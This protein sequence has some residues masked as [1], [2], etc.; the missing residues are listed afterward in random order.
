MPLERIF[1][2][3]KRRFIGLDPETKRLA[4]LEGEQATPKTAPPPPKAIKALSGSGL[5]PLVSGSSGIQVAAPV[6]IP[7]HQENDLRAYGTQLRDTLLGGELVQQSVNVEA[8]GSMTISKTYAVPGLELRPGIAN[9]LESHMAAMTSGTTSGDTVWQGWCANSFTSQLATSCNVSWHVWTTN[10]V[11]AATTIY[12]TSTITIQASNVIYQQAQNNWSGWAKA[13]HE[14][15][16]QKRARLASEATLRQQIEAENRRRAEELR[17]FQ[18]RE[19]K[20][21]ARADKLLMS[22]L[23]EEQKKSLAEKK[24][25]EV[26][27]D[28]KMFRIYRGV[29]GNIKELDSENREIASYCV[30]PDGVPVGDVMLTQLLWLRAD[31]EA[32]FRVANKTVLAPRATPPL[33]NPGR[34]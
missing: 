24:Y 13:Y 15:K 4:V 14:T 32:L 34:L 29:A 19:A 6:L 20:A 10:A 18:E 31:K 30:H 11:T 27:V 26:N 12:P 7:P 8:N 22:H 1:G 28:G 9:V 5:T 25:F 17:L 21:N 2:P 23:T 16:E 3:I 33:I